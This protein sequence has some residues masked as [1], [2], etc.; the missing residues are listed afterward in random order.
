MYVLDMNVFLTLGHY[1]PDRFPSI[2]ERIDL[3]VKTQKL[4][5]VREVK[6]ELDKNCH[7]DHIEEWVSIN[8]H[9]F[10]IPTEKEY[11]VVSEIFQK[12][13][14]QGLVKRQNL[15]KGLPVADPFIV[16]SAKVHSASVVTQEKYKKNGARV[17]TVCKEFGVNCINVEQFLEKEKLKF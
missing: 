1:Y 3:L 7:F 13:N 5:S 16:A 2:W 15:M 14:Y 10:K 12:T 8:R 9:I 17:P 11:R 4:W 6:R